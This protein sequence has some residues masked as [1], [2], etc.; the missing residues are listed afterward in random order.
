MANLG[1]VMVVT[2]WWRR[3]L[4]GTVLDELLF[5]QNQFPLKTMYICF[6]LSYLAFLL[7]H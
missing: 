2:V 3:E 5:D 1:T 7:S 6:V 4:G